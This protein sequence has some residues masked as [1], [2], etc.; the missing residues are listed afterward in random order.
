[1]NARRIMPSPPPAWASWDALMLAALEEA[2]RA[3][4]RGEVPVGALVVAPDGGILGRG[5]N[6]PVAENDPTAHAEIAAIRMAA[7]RAG[8]YRLNGCVLVVTLEPCLMCVGAIVQARL[9]GVAFG[10]FDPKAGA[11]SSVLDGFDL[12]AHNHVPWQAGG[13][14]EAECGALLR[15]FFSR[16]R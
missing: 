2:A 12:P 4:Q 5:H 3:E 16:R 1:M 15:T 8:N 11:A 14:L 6:A 9:Q 10:A 13:I 7:A